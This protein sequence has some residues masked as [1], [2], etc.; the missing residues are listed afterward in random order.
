MFYPGGWRRSD[1]HSAG[2]EAR[3]LSRPLD[4]CSQSRLTLPPYDLGVLS[5]ARTVIAD[6]FLAKSRSAHRNN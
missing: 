6:D 3:S 1:A 5:A 2:N 4:R